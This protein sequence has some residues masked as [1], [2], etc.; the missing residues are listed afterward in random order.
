MILPEPRNE[1][2]VLFDEILNKK[3]NDNDNGNLWNNSRFSLPLDYYRLWKNSR[4]RRGECVWEFLLR[5]KKKKVDAFSIL[6][7]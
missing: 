3:N 5:G 4:F 6:A 1:G 2:G 7:A